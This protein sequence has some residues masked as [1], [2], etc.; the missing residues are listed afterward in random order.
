MAGG[1]GPAGP[2]GPAGG[3]H[4]AQGGAGGP[5]AAGGLGSTGGRVTGEAGRLTET[6]P[7]IGGVGRTV[8]SVGGV[9]GISPQ[10]TTKDLKNGNVKEVGKDLNKTVKNLP[11]TVKN[12]PKK[13][14]DVTKTLPKVPKTV[15]KEVKLPA[16]G[17]VKTGE[18]GKTGPSITPPQTNL[19]LPN[20][21][22]VQLSPLP[23]TNLTSGLGL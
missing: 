5:L 6:A 9:V 2:S 21:G 23:Q 14:N 19:P 7:G 20:L 18:A 22:P 8:E 10:K 16:G 4:G 15:P 1:S 3:S 17:S 13:V 11:Q 12:A